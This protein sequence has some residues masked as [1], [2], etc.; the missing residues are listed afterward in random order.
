M[1]ALAARFSDL[2][3][4]KDLAPTE[5]GKPYAAEAVKV[6]DS[7]RQAPEEPNMNHLQGSILLAFFFYTTGPSSKAWVLTGI[8]IRLAYDLEVDQTDK[9]GR[10]V[11]PSK[12]WIELEEIRRAWWLVWELDTFASITCNRPFA[13]PREE[14]PVFLP[15]SD[16]AWF[17]GTS[18]ASTTLKTT[19]EDAWKSLQGSENQNPRAWFLV[20]NYLSS[21]ALAPQSRSYEDILSMDLS[22]NCFRFALPKAFHPPFQRHL[23]CDQMAERNWVICTFL[24]LSAYKAL[25]VPNNLLATATADYDP[26]INSLRAFNAELAYIVD[27]W[28]TDALT[29]CQPLIACTLIAS[30][31][32]SRG[33]SDS[34]EDSSIRLG[35]ALIEELLKRFAA[36][37]EIGMNLLS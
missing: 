6:Y 24:T 18:T 3:Y 34:L 37:W 12:D 13:I 26:R 29:V 17:S 28:P 19:P 23:S 11:F 25:Q 22:V 35:R 2:T 27:A 21:V 16:E 8:L 5:R 9:I 30:H 31:H 7:S 36:T 14:V 20:A 32:L 10:N 33:L 4:L 1:F 15:V